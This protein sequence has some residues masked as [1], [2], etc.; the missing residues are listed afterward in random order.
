VTR[1]AD[2]AAFAAAVPLTVTAPTAAAFAE[3]VN[4][5][6]AAS[7][8]RV[9]ALPGLGALQGALDKGQH[10]RVQQFAPAGQPLLHRILAQLQ[11]VSHLLNGLMFPVE[12]IN[13]SR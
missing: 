3:V 7:T 4:K 10:L 5:G 11:R 12:R 13:G 8:P 6:N 1:P 2:A 9:N